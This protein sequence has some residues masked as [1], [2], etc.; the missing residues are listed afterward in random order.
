MSRLGEIRPRIGDP[1]MVFN[2]RGS[3]NIIEQQERDSGSKNRKAQK[4]EQRKFLHQEFMDGLP[5]M[6]FAR[7]LSH[8][9]NRTESPEDLRYVF[10]HADDFAQATAVIKPKTK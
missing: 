8:L 5:G 1:S 6:Q 7:A 9:L 3:K 4:S 10:Q 2:Q